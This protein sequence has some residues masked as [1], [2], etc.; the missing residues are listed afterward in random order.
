MFVR[1][2]LQHLLPQ[3]KS[4]LSDS[5]ELWLTSCRCWDGVNLDPPDHKVGNQRF[6][7]IKR[8]WQLDIEPCSLPYRWTK[9][10]ILW[11]CVPINSPGITSYPIHGNRLGHE[12]IQRSSL[13]AERWQSAFRPQ[14]GWSVSKEFSESFFVANNLSKSRL[15]ST[16][17]LCVWMGRRFSTISHGYLH[18][19]L[20]YSLG[21]SSPH[22]SRCRCNE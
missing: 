6:F 15:W 14:Y 16:R 22:P 7:I 3:V 1:Y 11:G 20:G 4:S 12:G 10:P 9:L 18:V 17:R 19:R 8:S 13:V 21:V 2:P 5:V